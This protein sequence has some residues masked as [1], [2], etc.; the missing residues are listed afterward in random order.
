M[1]LHKFDCKLYCCLSIQGALIK[2]NHVK[3]KFYK[4]Y[5]FKVSPKGEE[6]LTSIQ[7]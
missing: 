6:R 3:K 7:A 4:L 2:Q 5:G 1:Q